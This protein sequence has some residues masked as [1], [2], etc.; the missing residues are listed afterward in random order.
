MATNEALIKVVDQLCIAHVTLCKRV[1]LLEKLVR[2]VHDGCSACP[3]GTLAEDDE[4]TDEG[5]GLIART[6]WKAN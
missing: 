5:A 1:E 2:S 6:A 3:G 4:I